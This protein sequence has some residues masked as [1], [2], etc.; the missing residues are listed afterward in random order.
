MKKIWMGI[1][2]L[3]PGLAVADNMSTIGLVLENWS[4]V[5]RC[6]STVLPDQQIKHFTLSIDHRQCE[7]ADRYIF[8]LV[9]EMYSERDARELS[10]KAEV[11]GHFLLTEVKRT[12]EALEYEQLNLKERIEE[13][14]YCRRVCQKFQP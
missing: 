10:L 4:L 7:I 14:E 3:V 13:L 1:I 8:A 12:S 5:S 11:R 2:F 9:A 6:S